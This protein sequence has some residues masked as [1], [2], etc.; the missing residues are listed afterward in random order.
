MYDPTEEKIASLDLETQIRAVLLV[1]AAREAGIPLMVISGRR[2][3]EVN[4]AVGG[5]SAS[6]H[7]TG[8]A[9]DVQILGFTR[10]QIP[11][12]WWQAL[13]LY[14]EEQLGLRWGGRFNDWN[15]FDTAFL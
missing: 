9:F 15:H 5:A 13:G 4:E 1:N 11:T 6:Y 8:Q 10:D 3:P 12:P 7:L 14:A 2:S